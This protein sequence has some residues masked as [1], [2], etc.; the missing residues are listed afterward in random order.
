[1]AVPLRSAALL[2]SAASA[3]LHAADPAPAPAI[4]HL[5]G[6]LH[7][8]NGIS[9]NDA[10]RSIS[11]PAKFNLLNGPLEYALVHESGKAHESLLTTAISPFDLN[12]VLLLLNYQPSTTFFDQSNKAAG[13]IVV[14]N[15]KIDPAS[16]LAV[17]LQWKDPSGTPHSARLESLIR[18]LDRKAPA[19]K[20]PFT[21]TGSML[22]EDGTFMAKETGSILALYADAAAL[23][24]N[25]RPGNQ[26]DD[27]WVPHPPSLPPKGTPLT[28]T[29][30]PGP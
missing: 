13:A 9:F 8:L 6:P 20:G 21:Y 14:E 30:S 19:S 12:V 10:T 29:F 5:G 25:P 3:T 1:M 4:R 17:N 16:N 7:E 26:N 2:L 27:I 22:M 11:F 23:F 18:N 24:N 15:P 28:V